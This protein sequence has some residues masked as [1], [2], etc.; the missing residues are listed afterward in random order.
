MNDTVHNGMDVSMRDYKMGMGMMNREAAGTMKAFGAFMGEALGDG[1]LDAKT[2]ELIALGMAITA[3]CV[4][5]I[6][7][8][9]EK[10]LRA[11]VSHAEIVEVCKVAIVMGGGPA[12]TY[13]AEVKKALDL[14]EQVRA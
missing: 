5:C 2:K 7:I 9:V 6:G 12:M 8:H 13:I 3:R 14:F 10:C 11:G 1:V 4:Y